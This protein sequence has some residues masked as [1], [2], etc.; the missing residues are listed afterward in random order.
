MTKKRPVASLRKKSFIVI[1][2]KLT[3]TEVLN[4]TKFH[5]MLATKVG[6][7]WESL[8][9]YWVGID[10]GICREQL[11]LDTVWQG[12]NIKGEDCGD[13]CLKCS[14]VVVVVGERFKGKWGTFECRH[15]V[16][17]SEFLKEV[18]DRV[19]VEVKRSCSKRQHFGT[20]TVK[21]LSPQLVYSLNPRR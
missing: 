17:G 10:A 3:E 15:L 11:R 6:V 12:W 13:Y 20:V 9:C 2:S 19:L 18:Q 21:G 7:A 1:S 8:G 14:P 5:L 16:T 4:G